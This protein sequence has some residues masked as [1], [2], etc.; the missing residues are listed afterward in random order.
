MLIPQTVNSRDVQPSVIAR[1]HADL[2]MGVFLLAPLQSERPQARESSHST[3]LTLVEMPPPATQSQ[4]HVVI[5]AHEKQTLAKIS[6]FRGSD[7]CEKG[8]SERASEQ[9]AN[10][11]A[12]Q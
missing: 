10:Q 12:T 9:A 3:L 6:C 8:V 1:L 11:P 2:Q 5:R 7:D 4:C